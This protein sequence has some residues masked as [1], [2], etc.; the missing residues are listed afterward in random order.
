MTAP[1]T[2]RQSSTDCFRPIAQKSPKETSRADVVAM[3]ENVLAD[4]H[5]RE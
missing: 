4:R 3:L 1:S 2:R 5:G